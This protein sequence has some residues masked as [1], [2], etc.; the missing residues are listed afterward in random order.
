[1]KKDVAFPLSSEATRS[2][3]RKDARFRSS[4]RPPLVRTFQK[5]SVRRGQK[6]RG[7]SPATQPLGASSFTWNPV[8]VEAENILDLVGRKRAKAGRQ[9]ADLKPSR[10]IESEST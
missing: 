9:L 8:L 7:E 2:I 6:S 1:M 5:L 3:H 4:S 10:T